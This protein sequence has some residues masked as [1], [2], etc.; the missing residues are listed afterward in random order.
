MITTTSILLPAGLASSRICQALDPRA[1]NEKI[2]PL[3]IACGRD[4]S[5]MREKVNRIGIE[6]AY[7]RTAVPAGGV[8]THSISQASLD[9]SPHIGISSG[10]S[11]SMVDIFKEQVK[12]VF[13]RF[14]SMRPGRRHKRKSRRSG[15]AGI[16]SVQYKSP[17]TAREWL[18][19]RRGHSHSESSPI[20]FNY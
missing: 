1:A 7:M 19:R 8:E 17:E 5:A 9:K 2:K 20:F 18:T 4:D 10:G 3:W 11:I 16:E 15:T 12:P 14:G 6:H 13:L